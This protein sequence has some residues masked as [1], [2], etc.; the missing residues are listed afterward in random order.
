MM[1]SRDLYRLQKLEDKHCCELFIYEAFR[2]SYAEVNGTKIEEEIAT[3][4][5]GV[6]LVADVLGAS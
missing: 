2:G 6:P 4:C 3:K 1:G 5:N